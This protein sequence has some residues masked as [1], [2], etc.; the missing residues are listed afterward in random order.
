MCQINPSFHIP[1]L[2]WLP[3]SIFTKMAKMFD[4]LKMFCVT[5]FL[6][7]EKQMSVAFFGGN[8]KKQL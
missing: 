5:I 1:P 8:G 6:Q 2:S 3:K 7:V 4:K